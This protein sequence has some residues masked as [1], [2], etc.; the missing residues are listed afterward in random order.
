MPE[1]LDIVGQDEA[2]GQLQRALQSGR[3]PHAFL[4]AGPEGVGRET[5]AMQLAK[6]LKQNPRQLAANSCASRSIA[7]ACAR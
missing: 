5:T 1:L 7:V 4:F 6:P 3:Q 2:L